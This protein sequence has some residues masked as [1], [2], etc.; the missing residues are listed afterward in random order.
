M[1]KRLYVYD[2]LNIVYFEK[3]LDALIEELSDF[4][5]LYPN[6]LSY[7]VRANG[8]DTIKVIGYRL[9][10]DKEYNKRVSKIKKKSPNVNKDYE[11]VLSS[12]K[13]LNK[14]KEKLEKI[15]EKKNKTIKTEDL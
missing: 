8:I 6:Y 2:D 9:E 1:L 10:T 3:N 5:R 13:K 12:L 11:R 15:I 7:E 4:P 14:K